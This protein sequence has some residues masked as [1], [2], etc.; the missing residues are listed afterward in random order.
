MQIIPA[1]GRLSRLPRHVLAPIA[2]QTVTVVV[3][4]GFAHVM[5]AIVTAARLRQLPAHL[6]VVQIKAERFERHPLAAKTVAV[7]AVRKLC[8][9]KSQLG[10]LN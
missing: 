10:S 2:V 4:Q 1:Q 5:I 3:K 9:R 8:R 6:V 7:T